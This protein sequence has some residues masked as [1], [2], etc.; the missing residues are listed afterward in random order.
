MPKSDD[1]REL[2]ASLANG[3]DRK[4]LKLQFML[5]LVT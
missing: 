1:F 2:E 3:L 4:S 5:E